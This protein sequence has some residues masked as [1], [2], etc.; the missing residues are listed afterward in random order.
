MVNRY[1][2]LIVCQAL[3]YT[4][5]LRWE[6]FFR[7]SQG[8]VGNICRQFP[9]FGLVGAGITTGISLVE[10]KPYNAQ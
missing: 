1:L 10:T 3:F 5:V 8:L 9:L 6:P 2:V 4:E 7:P